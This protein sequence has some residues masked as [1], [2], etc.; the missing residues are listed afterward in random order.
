[1]FR[2]IVNAIYHSFYWYKIVLIL[3]YKNM[4]FYVRHLSK[5]AP[6]D[7]MASERLVVT[8]FHKNF[9][10]TKANSEE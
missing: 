7:R 3:S 5:K 2:H 10:K 9:K 4:Q 6:K 1:M 8:T